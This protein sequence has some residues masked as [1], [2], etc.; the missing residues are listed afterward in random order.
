MANVL[1]M[2]IVEAIH[3]LRSAGLSC[4]AIAKRL[5]IHRETVSRY[6]RLGQEPVSKPANAPIFPAGT[7]DRVAGFEAPTGSAAAGFAA[8]AGSGGRG[9]QASPW[10]AWL[11]EERAKGLSATRIHQDLL[12]TFPGAAAVS[13]DSVRRLLKKHAAASPVPF[14]RMETAPGMEA[15]IDFGTGAPVI[16]PDGKR[17]KTHV[18]RI[19]LSHS[20]RGYSEVV[21]RQS[22][23]EFIHCLENAFEHFGG[24]PRTLVVDS[25]KAAVLQADWFD[26]EINPKFADFC[27]HY[28]TVV[29]P[30]KPR[31]PRHKGKTE[32][33]IAYVQDNALKG[34]KFPSLAAQNEFLEQWEANTAD[35]RIHGTTKQQVLAHFN[36]AERE[37]LLPLP[38]SRFE[39]FREAKRKVS[40]DGHVEVDRAFYS[41][42]PE[43]LG[44]EV[45][46]RFTSRVVRIFNLRMKQIAFHPKA[47]R[48]RFSTDMHHVPAS[49][50]NILER[51]IAYLLGKVKSVGPKTHAWAE[52]VVAA[53]GIEGHRVVQGLIALTRKHA[54]DELESACETALSYQCYT[55]RTL[56][57]LIGRQAEQQKPLEFLAEHPLI[58]PLDA[59]GQ[60]VARAIHRRQSRP[61]MGE[62]FRSHGTGI[63]AG[64]KSH[65]PVE[66][67][68]RGDAGEGE[69]LWSG[70]RSPGCSSA[71]PDSCSPD[72]PTIAPDP[73]P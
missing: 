68:P 69:C 7:S 25:L 41:V 11:L 4:R 20:R 40:R 19:V 34:R 66:A 39:N 73:S 64:T 65:R 60:V 10:L 44:H 26:P 14:R 23:D 52:A 58:R 2:T 29:L 57:K 28:D 70:Y 49:K 5:G 1:K 22:T 42:P 32:R 72:S 62:G 55:L 38:P 9:S 37:A 15:Q 36:A 6:V 51:G 50:I 24:V 71:E 30:T 47:D 18:L 3:S 27:R 63:P 67:N 8:P 46:V 43:Y 13:Y 61:S 16:G 48:G 59:Y 45:W 17:R 33:G 21:Y 53:R 54:P 56:R 35:R 31:T 12:A